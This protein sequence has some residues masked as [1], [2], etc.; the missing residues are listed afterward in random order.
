MF[1][2][3]APLAVFAIALVVGRASMIRFVAVA[4]YIGPALTRE[5]GLWWVWKIASMS[6]SSC[7]DR[8]LVSPTMGWL[9]RVI[10]PYT[11]REK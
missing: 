1:S 8:L 9:E 6:F 4:P 5:S 3:P 2:V 11:E 10:D 7:T